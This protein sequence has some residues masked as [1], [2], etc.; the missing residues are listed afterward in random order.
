LA[1][2]TRPNY[3]PYNASKLAVLNIMWSFA[4][5]LGPNGTSVNAVTPGPVNTATWEQFAETRARA[6]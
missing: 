4:Q 1:K 3:L 2:E 6:R 5:I